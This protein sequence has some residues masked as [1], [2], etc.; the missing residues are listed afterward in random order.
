MNLLEDDVHIILAALRPRRISWKV[1]VIKSCK[2]ER[3]AIHLSTEQACNCLSVPTLRE[4]GHLMHLPNDED[5]TPLIVNRLFS[6]NQLYW[7][8]AVREPHPS[9]QCYL[10][11]ILHGISASR[12]SSYG[13][14]HI[15]EIAGL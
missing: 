6:Q 10:V 8:P 9:G 4:S 15:F 1:V 13:Q 12:P 7:P 3:L 14:N 5:G 2:I 11:H